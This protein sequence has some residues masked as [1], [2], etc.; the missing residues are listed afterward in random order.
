MSLGYKQIRACRICGSIDLEPTL[1]LGKHALSGVFPR[2]QS[3]AVTSGPL[4]LVRCLGECGLLQLEHTYNLSEMYGDN[5]GYR[6]GLNGGMK[7]HLQ[8]KVRKIL[9]LYHPPDGSVILDIA[10]ND[11]TVLAAY[12]ECYSLVGIDPTASKFRQYYPDHVTLIPDFFSAKVFRDVFGNKQVSIITSFAMFYDLESPLDFV[13]EVCDILAPDGIWVF[14]QSYLPTMIQKNSYDTVCHEHLEYYGMRQIQW[15]LDRAGLKAIDIELNDINGGSFSVMAAKT[16]NP[17]PESPLLKDMLENEEKLGLHSPQIY[18]DFSKQTVR[19]RDAVLDF[20]SDR[21]RDG[22]L[23]GALGA[24]TKGNVFLQYCKLSPNEIVSIG[25][26]NDDKFGSFTPGTLVPI[27]PEYEL[28]NSKPD[29]L[30]V[31][32]W[33]FRDTFVNKIK[34]R[35]SLVFAIP[36]LEIIER[37]NE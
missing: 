23:V 35:A 33:H 5:Y 36:N 11:G 30:I 28:M 15:L 6:S 2:S 26:I 29:Y 31:L 16:E 13:R 27:V 9:S 8:N 34:S 7:K 3:Q 22:K 10:S 20:F 1:D 18:K 4:R 32:P 21:K 24:S 37:T 12:P 19:N 25:E 17:I 14:E